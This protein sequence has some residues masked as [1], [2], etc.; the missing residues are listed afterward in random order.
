MLFFHNS[1]K[2]PII[3]FVKFYSLMTSHFRTL[4]AR[5]VTAAIFFEKKIVLTPNMAALSRGAN[6]ELVR[7]HGTITRTHG[8]LSP[9]EIPF[10]V[11]RPVVR[12]AWL[13]GRPLV[14]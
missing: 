5:D 4:S 10:T 8:T 13:P 1:P 3:K 7:S 9:R 11:V 6:Q 2:N 14:K 12:G